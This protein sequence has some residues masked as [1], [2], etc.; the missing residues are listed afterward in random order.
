[1]LIKKD[2]DYG[3]LIFLKCHS[4]DILRA[5]YYIF[6]LFYPTNKILLIF[7]EKKTKKFETEN[8]C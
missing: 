7:I 6:K 5:L 4:H 8:V 1:M 2:C 3:F